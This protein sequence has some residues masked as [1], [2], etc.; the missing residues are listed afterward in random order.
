MGGLMMRRCLTAV[1]L[2]LSSSTQAAERTFSV[3]DFERIRVIGPFKVTVDAA[4]ATTAKASGTPQSLDLVDMRVQNRTLMIQAKQPVSSSAKPAPATIIITT[5]TPLI[6]A[7]ISG[8]GNLTVN[9]VKGLKTA[10]STTGSGS[11]TATNIDAD[12]LDVKAAGSG[13]VTLSGKAKTLTINARGAPGFA[14]DALTALDLNLTWSSAGSG[15]FRATRTAK[16]KINGA[17]DVT[18]NGSADCTVLAEGSGTVVCKALK[19]RS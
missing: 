4:R 14:A 9:R 12:L 17:G 11:L 15:V 1:L 6:D 19:V 3:T 5:G 13:Q 18:I 16:G 7:Q 2:I 8:P 10:L